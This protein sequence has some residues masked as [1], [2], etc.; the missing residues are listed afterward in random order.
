MLSQLLPSAPVEGSSRASQAFGRHSGGDGDGRHQPLFG[1]AARDRDR[2]RNRPLD[3]NLRSRPRAS[4]GSVL[5]DVESQVGRNR[6]SGFSGGRLSAASAFGDDLL[7]DDLT[8]D[9]GLGRPSSVRGSGVFPRADD[10]VF[11]CGLLLLPQSL[12][13]IRYASAHHPALKD[14]F[15]ARPPS[16]AR[17]LRSHPPKATAALPMTK[18]SLTSTCPK[19]TRTASSTM[20]L[21][22]PPL[23][24]GLRRPSLTGGSRR[25][26]G[27]C[28]E[29]GSLRVLKW[30]WILARMTR[31]RQA[32]RLDL[33]QS[34]NK[35]E[36]PSDSRAKSRHWPSRHLR[37]L[38][39]QL[40]PQVS[41]RKAKSKKGT[42]ASGW[43][44]NSINPPSTF[45][46]RSTKRP[47]PTRPF[48]RLLRTNPLWLPS[49]PKKPQPQER[50]RR[51]TSRTWETMKMWKS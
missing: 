37:P 32:L 44:Q 46:S 49:S 33:R 16:A 35:R 2:D 20:T 25:W 42:M 38:T 29:T 34:S 4:G 47:V 40:G 27:T 31:V 48:Y 26:Q 6:L 41:W 18:P 13:Y 28:P 22:R 14:P 45:P 24:A 8:G 23:A 30:T 7:D 5:S 51:S 12:A 9:L 39:A 21:S 19:T 3:L 1:S 36:Q 50:T 15:L 10:R 11:R 43:V 17:S